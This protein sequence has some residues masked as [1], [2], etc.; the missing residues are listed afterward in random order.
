M[1]DANDINIFASNAINDNVGPDG[2]DFPCARHET[3]PAALRQIFKP[4]TGGNQL[5][6][7][8]RGGEWVVLPDIGPDFGRVRQGLG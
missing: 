6:G 7:D 5:Y 2:R 1:P 3:K 4:V 8:P